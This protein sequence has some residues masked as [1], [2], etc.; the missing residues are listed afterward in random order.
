MK[1]RSFLCAAVLVAASSF[2]SKAAEYTS[3]PESVVID[4]SV[5]HYYT[6]VNFKKDKD[7]F[8]APM[9]YKG[10]SLYLD[11]VKLKK[12]ELR[13]ICPDKMKKYNTGRTLRVVG[14]SVTGIGVVSMGFGGYVIYEGT[15]IANGE[16]STIEE[17]IGAAF[18]TIA[19]VLIGAVV[20]VGGAIVSA[21]GGVVWG[22]GA[23]TIKSVQKDYNNAHPTVATELKLGATNNGFGLALNF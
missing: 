14:M 4:E 18:G 7:L 20:T 21:V 11:G 2:T 5:F 9:T 13:E 23:G 6:D 19:V 10:G 22:S 3:E 15:Q 8:A 1:L 12:A 17:G 16:A